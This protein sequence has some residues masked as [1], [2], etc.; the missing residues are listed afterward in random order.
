MKRFLFPT[1]LLLAA[2][3]C[4]PKTNVPAEVPIR[5]YNAPKATGAITIDG[6]LDE[7]DWQNAPLSDA[8]ADIRGVDFEPKPIKQTHMKM[9]WEWYDVEYDDMGYA[10][11]D[12]DE[13][14]AFVQEK[15]DH[16]PRYIC[17]TGGMVY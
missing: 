15:Y 9:L 14:V 7:A 8:F 16:R 12:A 5:T 13:Y 11:L 6:I 4:A 1:L 2:A 3:A 10:W 17:G